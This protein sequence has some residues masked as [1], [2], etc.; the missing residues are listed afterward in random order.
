MKPVTPTFSHKYLR[1]KA[2]RHGHFLYNVND[3]FVGKS[4]D[5]YGEWAEEELEILAQLIHPGD[6]V[7]DIG[8]YIGTH[9]VFFANQVGPTGHVHSFEPQRFAY[10]LLCANVAVNL[11]LNVTCHNLMVS[12]QPGTHKVPLL[13]PSAPFNFGALR[14]HEINAGI[15]TPVITIDQLQLSQCHLIKI[16][17][18]Q[19]EAQVLTGA[20]K[21]IAHHHPILFVENNTVAAS[22]EILKTLKA[23]KYKAFW[24][25]NTYFNPNNYFANPTNIFPRYQPEANLLCVPNNAKTDIQ[26]LEPVMGINDNFLKATRRLHSKHPIPKPKSSP[27]RS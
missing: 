26:G 21:T 14:L 17:V 13:N 20:R 3:L 1:L 23:L 18:E 2:C 24:H 5:L 7:L 25:I 6:V 16:D 19:M 11:H 27:T 9:T 4:L 10:Y 22:K 15:P 12:H 8:A